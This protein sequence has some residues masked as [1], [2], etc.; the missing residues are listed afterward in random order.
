M[1]LF[2]PDDAT[3]E[4]VIVVDGTS[5]PATIID[6]K[7]TGTIKDLT[8]GDHT[9][10]VKYAGDDKY[11]GVEVTEVVNVAKADAVLGVVIADVD[12]GNGFV[13]EATLTGVNNAPFYLV[14]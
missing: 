9:V 5:Y 14:M 1:K 2:L 4:V 10:V 13:I 7:A 12:Y 11:S 6:G 8:A 3:G